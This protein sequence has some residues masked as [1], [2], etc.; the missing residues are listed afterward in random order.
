M[1]KKQLKRFHCAHRNRISL[2]LSHSAFFLWNKASDIF[3]LIIFIC[4]PESFVVLLSTFMLYL[5]VQKGCG[6]VRD[7][8]LMYWTHENISGSI[9]WQGVWYIECVQ[10][11]SNAGQTGERKFVFIAFHLLDIQP[12]KKKKR[13][14]CFWLFGCFLLL[15]L[16][17]TQFFFFIVVA[18]RLM[19]ISFVDFSLLLA[20]RLAHQ[21]RIY[22]CNF[23]VQ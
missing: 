19:F 10:L 13:D 20:F 2:V 15:L 21:S 16:F 11:H 3:L 9:V 5:Y 14:F 12:R 1:K 4:A 18:F 8:Q 6:S 23:K 7:M 22:S 17:L